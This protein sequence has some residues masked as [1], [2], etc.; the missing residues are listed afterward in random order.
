MGVVYV[1]G[2]NSDECKKI[3]C[4]LRNDAKHRMRSVQISYPFPLTIVRQW[5]TENPRALEQKLHSEF[6]N[7]HERGE[8]FRLT[9]QDLKRC[10]QVAKDFSSS[11]DLRTLTATT[12]KP[13]PKLYMRFRTPEGKQPSYCAAAFDGKS[14]LRPF[15]CLVKGTAE[16]HPEATYYQRTK[17]D[18]KEAGESLG[19]DANAAWNKAT[20]G[21]SVDTVKHELA[22]Q[23]TPPK[24]P[25]I[26]GT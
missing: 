7:K 23:L 15:W 2:S 17:R 22:V 10:D 18:G 24:P 8:W 13:R 4:S 6:A 16:H 3:G 14:R 21:K 11:D 19:T 1:F 20:V 25:S 9:D 12:N 26:I 5:Q